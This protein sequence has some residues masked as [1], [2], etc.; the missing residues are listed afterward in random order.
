MLNVKSY[1]H[2]AET[3]KYRIVAGHIKKL[4]TAISCKVDVFCRK[5]NRLLAS[6]VSDKNGFYRVK[7]NTTAKVFIVSHDPSLEFNAVIQDN[8]V[9]K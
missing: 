1:C 9:P 7:V 4:G 2:A 5:T 3:L 8:V 6:T